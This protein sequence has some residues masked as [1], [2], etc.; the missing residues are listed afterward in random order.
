L[1]SGS[2]TLS[3]NPGR[4]IT[5][6]GLIVEYPE[7]QVVRLT[8][9]HGIVDLRQCRRKPDIG[10]SITIIPNHASQVMNLHDVAYGMRGWSVEVAWPIRARGCVR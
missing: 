1:D 7:A 8:E 10:E 4:G 2:K 3:S 5:G 9:E 6:F